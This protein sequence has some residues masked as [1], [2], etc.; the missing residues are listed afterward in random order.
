MTLALVVVTADGIVMAADS[1]TSLPLTASGSP[2]HRVAS[3]CTRKVFEA[4]DVAIATFG[5]ALLDGRYVA[6]HMADFVADEKTHCT[7]PEPAAVRLAKFFGQL[8]DADLAGPGT[9][10]AGEATLGFLV[11]GYAN[12][13]GE[14]YEVTI[15]ARSIS[16]I[17][18]TTTGGGAA[19]RGE[20]AVV[21]RFLRGADLDLLERVA[22][23]K[24]KRAEYTALGPALE[25]LS[26]R[27]PYNVMN[28]QDAIDFAVV[29][30]RTTIEVQRLTLGPEA[31]I[32]RVRWPDVGGPIE[33][34][35][36]TAADKFSWLQRSALH[37]EHPASREDVRP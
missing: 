16:T 25:A 10:P 2:G 32:A 8:Y 9:A 29:C 5:E 11:G 7:A 1:R 30:I 12:A 23:D 6:S 22:A 35:T 26:Y 19:W 17:A 34:A 36:V 3:D 14:A 4:G 24:G 20:V 15:P 18:T 28:L 33:I 21:N 13:I 31:D 37:G 27:V